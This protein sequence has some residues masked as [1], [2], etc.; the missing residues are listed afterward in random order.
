MGFKDTRCLFQIVS[1]NLC[2][3]FFN[4]CHFLLGSS[5]L[6]W[7]CTHTQPHRFSALTLS[8][9]FFQPAHMGDL[10]GHSWIITSFFF[11]LFFLLL[12][13]FPSWYST[14]CSFI[15][16]VLQWQQVILN[17]LVP[18]SKQ[19]YWLC[20]DALYK[21]YVCICMSAWGQRSTWFWSQ[22]TSIIILLRAALFISPR[23]YNQTCCA[24]LVA[25][26]SHMNR[27]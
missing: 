1:P 8:H 3:F 21:A 5:V 25:D 14:A 4:I 26:Q 10:K 15:L 18:F 9:P 23:F 24:Q 16:G 19:G 20:V 27:N 13:P 12:K 2:S 6:E 7:R 17:Y 11:F 22:T